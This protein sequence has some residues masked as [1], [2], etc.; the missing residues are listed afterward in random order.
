M[1][2]GK[3]LAGTIANLMRAEIGL[4]QAAADQL[5]NSGFNIQI[6]RWDIEKWQKQVAANGLPV[7]LKNMLQL[8]GVSNA[9]I[10]D[11]TGQALAASPLQIEGSLA[12]KLYSPQI[13]AAL[14]KAAI[15]VVKGFP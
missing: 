14:A 6:Y 3:P 13:K 7:Q 12:N 2:Q 1:A 10:A 9:E 4:R 5:V 8:I 15:D 11:L